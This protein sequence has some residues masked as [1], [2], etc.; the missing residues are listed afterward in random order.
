MAVLACVTALSMPF[1]ALKSNRHNSQLDAEDA[2]HT[3]TALVIL[4][5]KL[6]PIVRISGKVR[7]KLIS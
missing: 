4:F 6:L 1:A 7:M 5:T 2:A 3:K